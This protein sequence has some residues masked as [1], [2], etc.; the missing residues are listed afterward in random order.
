MSFLPVYEL[1]FGFAL[2]KFKFQFLIRSRDKKRLSDGG[3]PV[4]KKN[5]KDTQQQQQ[6]GKKTQ[7][8]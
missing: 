4:T 8:Q 2:K 7:N 1:D 6:S 5:E 3:K